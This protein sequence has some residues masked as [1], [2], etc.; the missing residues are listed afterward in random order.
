VVSK[1]RPRS[2]EPRKIRP[3]VGKRGD[4]LDIHELKLAMALRGKNAHYKIVEIQPRHFQALADQYPGAEA[5]PAMIELTGRV[6]G[7]IE[8]VEKQ[9]PDGFAESVWA[10]ISKGMLKQAKSF[11]SHAKA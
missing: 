5:W 6:E 2:G 8:A 10:S 11:L 1:C 7:A 4:Q 9:L 3:V